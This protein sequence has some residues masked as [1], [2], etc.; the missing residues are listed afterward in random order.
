[1]MPN[2][3]IGSGTGKLWEV[4]CET[5]IA[6]TADRMRLRWS[7]TPIA[8]CRCY[9]DSEVGNAEL[10]IDRDECLRR[11]RG[12]WMG[13]DDYHTRTGQSWQNQHGFYGLGIIQV[14]LP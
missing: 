11:L 5:E 8:D 13:I 10:R 1:V 4:T 7:C 3:M 9:S 2:R 14:G 6:L 12:P